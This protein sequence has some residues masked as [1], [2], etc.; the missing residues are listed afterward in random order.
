MIIK[1][2]RIAWDQGIEE[3]GAQ[4]CMINKEPSF[5]ADRG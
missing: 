1:K 4:S 3:G 2:F 5:R